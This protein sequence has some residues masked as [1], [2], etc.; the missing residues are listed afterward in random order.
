MSIIEPFAGYL[1]GAMRSPKEVRRFEG[2]WYVQGDDG[3]IYN[4]HPQHH[5]GVYPLRFK[6]EHGVD[7]NLVVNLFM[8]GGFE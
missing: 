7:Y 5:T 2:N 6:A 3:I 1:L 4:T 8:H